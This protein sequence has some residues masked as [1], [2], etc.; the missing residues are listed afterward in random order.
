MG[1]FLERAT[2]GPRLE[3]QEMADQ[4][5]TTTMEKQS[6]HQGPLWR[7]QTLEQWGVHYEAVVT[8]RASPLYPLSFLWF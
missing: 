4:T 8:Q 3:G 7:R 5:Q 2:S 1:D 6:F